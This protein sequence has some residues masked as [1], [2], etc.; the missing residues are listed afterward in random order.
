VLPK[1]R[2]FRWLFLALQL[3]FV[4]WIVSVLVNTSSSH[5]KKAC[6]YT[7]AVLA[8][9][10]KDVY[11]AGRSADI[12]VIVAIWVAVDVILGMSYLVWK[13]KF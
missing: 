10:C 8:Q 2:I 5:A 6:S 7:S 12:V 3:S 1:W 13:Q 4:G 9:A 11:N